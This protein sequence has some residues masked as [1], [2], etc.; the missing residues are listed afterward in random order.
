MADYHIS[1]IYQGGYSSLNPNYGPIFTGYRAPV[2]SIGTATSPFTINIIKEVADKLAPGQKNV[3]VSLGIFPDRAPI[4]AVPKQYLEEVKR[5]SKLTGVELSVHGPLTDASGI[6]R[7]G[8]DETQR[9][10]AERKIFQAVEK[11]HELNP[12]GNI[13]V[14]FHTANELP[15]AR[16]KK[17]W[18]GGKSEEFQDF[19]PVVNV[20]TGQITGVQRKK[21]Y[22]PGGTENAPIREEIYDVEKQ[23]VV[24]NQNEWSNSIDQVEFNRERAQRI[25]RD[26]HPIF[27]NKYLQL[28]FKEIKEEELLPEERDK[29]RQIG[30]AQA[31]LREAQKNLQGLFDRAYK[32]SEMEKDE[33]EKK[34]IQEDLKKISVDYSAILGIKEGKVDAGKYLNPLTQAEAVYELKEGLDRLQPKIYRPAEEYAIEQS[35]KTFGNVAWESYKKFGEKAPI[36]NIENPP[37]GFGLSRA[38]DLKNLVEQSRKKFVENAI[39]GGMSKNDA[40]KEAQKLIGAT[41]DVGHINQLRQFGFSGEDIVK[42]AAKVGH[43][44]KHVHLSDNFGMENVELPMGMGNVELKSVMEAL[45][46]G[47]TDVEKIKKIVETGHWWTH[48]QTSPIALTLEALGSPIYSVNL[49]PYWNQSSGFLQGYMGG[50]EGQWLPQGNYETFG[51]GFLNL[52]KELGGQ[53]GQ[54]GRSRMGGTP[55][56]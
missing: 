46:K 47:G 15:G 27:I 5:L 56:E 25:L 18:K 35:I 52:P 20:D 17:E 40:E 24:M 51:A 43:L 10:I 39:Q 26:I 13:P 36:I 38:E 29:M 30:S 37:A 23:I 4:E 1:D 16:W 33:M 8:F 41:W 45:K 19:M 12:D 55:M 31:Y 50:L 42:E 54:T 9:Q 22:A 32:I 3:E 53:R 2:S 7:Q 34:K 11:S 49:A 14:T 48:M 21:H 28:E 44:V 6:T